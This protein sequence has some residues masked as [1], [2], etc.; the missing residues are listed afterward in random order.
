MEYSLVFLKG[1]KFSMV[2]IDYPTSTAEEVVDQGWGWRTVQTRSF[3]IF[4]IFSNIMEL[5]SKNIQFLCSFLFH[6]DGFIVHH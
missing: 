4:Q 1:I 6:G 2:G 3:Q 5:S